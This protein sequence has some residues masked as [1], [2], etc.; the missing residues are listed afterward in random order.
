MRTQHAPSLIA[1]FPNG[2][3]GDSLLALGD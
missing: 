2:R 1:A 3:D